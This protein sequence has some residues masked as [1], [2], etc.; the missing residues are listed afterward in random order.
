[1]SD[2]KEYIEERV[3]KDRAF[4]EGM[5]EGYR[6]F[7]AECL[8][9]ALRALRK[10]ASLTQEDIAVLMKTKKSNVSRLENK[11]FDTKLSTVSNYCAAMNCVAELVI[12]SKDGNEVRLSL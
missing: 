6:K 5:E 3:T 4:A 1:M 11:T 8:G 12:R 7:R 2:L 10:E 9:E